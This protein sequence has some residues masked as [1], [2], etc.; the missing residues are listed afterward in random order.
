MFF[1]A[2]QGQAQ[3]RRDG[4]LKSKQYLLG[5]LIKETAKTR[6]VLLLH[7]PH[8]ESIFSLHYRFAEFMNSGLQIRSALGDHFV[9]CGEITK[10]SIPRDQD[11]GVKGFV[12]PLPPSS[13]FF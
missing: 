1:Y 13:L 8:I 6:H 2:A 9:S 11:G 5:D 10:I 12:H 7:I 4:K 3:I